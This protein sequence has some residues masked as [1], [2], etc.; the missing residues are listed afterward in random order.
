MKNDDIYRSQFRLPY[1]LYEKLKAEADKHHRSLN[2]EIVTRLS[3]SFE[4][5]ASSLAS[6]VAELHDAGKHH[7]RFSAESTAKA[8]IE[9]FDAQMRRERETI[10][11]RT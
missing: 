6:T 7:P 2:A 4:Q 9:G 1:D 5:P 8:F 10:F 3:E 11:R